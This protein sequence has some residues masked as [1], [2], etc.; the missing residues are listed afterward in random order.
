MTFNVVKY[1][2]MRLLKESKM[3]L[4]NHPLTYVATNPHT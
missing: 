1:Y 2:K 4:Y 3:S